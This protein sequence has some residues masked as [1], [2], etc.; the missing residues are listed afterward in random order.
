MLHGCTCP[1]RR[2]AL[3]RFA[4]AT[5]F[6]PAHLFIAKASPTDRL[7]G[8]LSKRDTGSQIC[9]F[10]TN[11]LAFLLI[12]LQELAR[13]YSSV[14]FP[15]RRSLQVRPGFQV[16]CISS[17][18]LRKDG[19]CHPAASTDTSQLAIR[20]MQSNNSVPAPASPAPVCATSLPELHQLLSSLHPV[21]RAQPEPWDLN[22]DLCGQVLCSGSTAQLFNINIPQGRRV[23][24]T[25]G[26]LQL[27]AD[28]CVNV[29]Q[30]AEL[31]LS[32]VVIIGPGSA[33]FGHAPAL[34]VVSGPGAC[35]TLDACSIF[36]TL[37]RREDNWEP[38]CV[39]VAGGASATLHNCIVTD[40]AGAGVLCTGQGSIV[41]ASHCTATRCA[42]GFGSSQAG[43]MALSHCMSCQ[44]Q[45]SGFFVFG[46]GSG[47]EVGPGCTAYHNKGYG[48]TAHG[49]GAVMRISNG[50]S[51]RQNGL[52]GFTS[53]AGAS[54]IIEDACAA[55]NN[56]GAGFAVM[57]YNSY[58]VVGRGCTSYNNTHTGFCAVLGG[59]LKV[60]GEAVASQ[61][62]RS[63]FIALDPC[64]HVELGPGCM[65]HS[66]RRH[67]FAASRGGRLLVGPGSEA[68]GNDLCGFRS[69]GHGSVVELSSSCRASSN[70]L[71]N[72]WSWWGGSMHRVEVDWGT[73][74]G[75]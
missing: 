14:Y 26:T 47:M 29:S 59:R 54:M 52:E 44:N 37:S 4:N 71:S 66:N 50:C 11:N 40:S 41:K 61:N 16:P 13:G 43:T 56:G 67:G 7:L 63:G 70:G 46:H 45:L 75:L 35:A 53:Q 8:R 9:G 62:G 15:A 28:C 42:Y 65:A 49:P 55:L 22:V 23:R 73:W 1:S 64:S 60:E 39:L 20:E 74:D 25:N 68:T 21:S 17:Q 24:I 32:G 5:R 27:P 19:S 36:M 3:R 34:L 38:E 12:T 33:R 58:M 48:F 51:A 2:L 18:T 6:P 69:S 57:E 31:Q 10:V 72:Y 30:G